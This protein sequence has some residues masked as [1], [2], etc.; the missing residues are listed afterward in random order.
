MILK[1]AQLGL[2]DIIANA[3]PHLTLSRDI[4]PVISFV[5]DACA[6]DQHQARTLMGELERMLNPPQSPPP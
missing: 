6:A 5:T 2:L 3:A 4:A 1:L